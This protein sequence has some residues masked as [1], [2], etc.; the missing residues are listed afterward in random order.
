MFAPF[1]ETVCGDVQNESG[2]SVA[3]QANVTVTLLLFQPF[4]LGVGVTAAVIRGPTTLNRM[5]L[6][7]TLCFMTTT[8]P[9]EAPAGTTATMLVAAHAVI[10]ATT[11]PNVTVLE[12]CVDAKFT[13]ATV[14]L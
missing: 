11:P 13:P 4:A 6:L 2:T 7:G 1:H 3:V 14:T 12:P 8:G 9:D 5:P 10:G